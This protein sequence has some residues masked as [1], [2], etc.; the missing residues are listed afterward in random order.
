MRLHR[1]ALALGLVAAVVWAGSSEAQNRKAGITGAAFLKVPVGA[2]AAALGSAYTTIE[3]DANQ[4]FWNPAGI[5]CD[6]GGMITIADTGNRRVQLLQY[7]R[8]GGST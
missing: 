1:S 5:S 3:G 2:R 7:R 4:L 6:S 8:R